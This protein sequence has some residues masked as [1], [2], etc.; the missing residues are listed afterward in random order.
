M[1]MINEDK[2]FKLEIRAVD[3]KAQRGNIPNRL[4]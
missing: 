1:G 4:H 2:D 3:V